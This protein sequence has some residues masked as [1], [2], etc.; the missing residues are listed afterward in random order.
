MNWKF[1]KKKKTEKPLKDNLIYAFTD[2][3]GRDYYRF[4]SPEVIPLIRL[5]KI[6]DFMGWMVRGLSADHVKQIADKMD[7]LLVSGLKTGR[8]GAKLGILIEELK[9]RNE[10]SVP[11]E[12]VYNYL[13][14]FYIRKDENPLIV[15]EQV[16][17]E[18]V[19][20]FKKSAE[21]GD[22]NE[23]FFALPEYKR[24]SELLNIT[25]NSWE[26]IVQESL[27]QMQKIEKLLKITSTEK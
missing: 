9:D 4:P 7:E 5:F 18:K 26:S 10:R 11:V 24:I 23:F 25:S 21:S 27:E 16:Q 2:S 22:M 8:N 1:W 15:N 6:Q 13:A 20:A 14:V 12:L 17:R 3:E 19:D